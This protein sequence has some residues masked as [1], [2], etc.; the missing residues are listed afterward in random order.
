M[1]AAW[2][3]IVGD[4][5]ASLPPPPPKRIHSIV[6]QK[7]RKIAVLNR[8]ATVRERWVCHSERPSALSADRS[9]TSLSEN[10]ARILP[11]REAARQGDGR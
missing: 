1:S 9:L 2:M 4:D 3:P 7:N 11:D 10:L 6:A 5:T 8:A